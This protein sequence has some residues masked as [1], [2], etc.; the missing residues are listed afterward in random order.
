MIRIISSRCASVTAQPAKQRSLPAISSNAS[1]AD[2]TR[3]RKRHCFAVTRATI[4]GNCASWK[5]SQWSFGIPAFYPAWPSCHTACRASSQPD[6]HIAICDN[7]FLAFQA[8][9]PA[10]LA[11]NSPRS[12]VSA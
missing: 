12:D 2:R 3:P 11:P 5:S 4:N 10:S 9:L 1:V 6:D 7:I 8:I